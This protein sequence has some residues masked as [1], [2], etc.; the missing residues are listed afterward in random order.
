MKGILKDNRKYFILFFVI[1]CLTLLSACDGITPINYTITATE[2]VGGQ[3]NPLGVITVN[4]GASQAFTITPDEGYQ[5]DDVLV[6]GI[7][8]GPI[9]FYSFTNIQQNHTIYATFVIGTSEFKVYNIDTGIGYDT[10]QEAIDAAL[11]GEIIIVYPGT[12]DENIVFDNRNITVQSTDP[13]DPSVVSATIIDGGRSGKVVKFLGG[14]TSN[15]QG[16][17]VQNGYEVSG[18]GIYLYNSSPNI[19]NNIITNN[20]ADAG[21]G[22]YVYGSSPT[23]E[24]N[25]ITNN[26]AYSGGGICVYGNSSAVITGNTIAGNDVVWGSGGGIYVYGSSPIITGNDI[27]GNTAGSGG[28]IYVDDSSPSIGGTN[29]ADIVNFNT[30]CGNSPDQIEPNDYPNNYITTFCMIA[31]NF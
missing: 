7:S 30:I 24:N 3:I 25:T 21:G 19:T 22:I 18:G 1:I 12:Y 8:E 11:D 14:D 9:T 26:A 15:L 2:G 17:T 27:M 20:E 28:G 23:V 10:I 16:F 29:T 31:L 5:I 13:S 6:D 4:E